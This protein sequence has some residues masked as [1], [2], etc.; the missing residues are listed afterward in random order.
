MRAAEFWNEGITKASWEKL[1]ELA[2][3]HDFV[4]IGGWAAWLWTKQHKSRDIDIVVDFKELG[5]LR[6]KYDV[7]KNERLKKY[8]IRLGDFDVDIYTPF[9]SKLELPAEE[10]LLEKVKIESIRTISC[11]SP[12]ILKQGAE[13]DRRGTV[14]G[15]K[16]MIDIMALLLWAPINLQDYFGKLENH[17]K[18]KLREELIREIGLFN[19][20]ESEK[21]LGIKLNEF[22]RRKKE[23]VKKV[24]AL[25]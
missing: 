8:E 19:P 20:A 1:Q 4:V 25:K 21:Y 24:K 6:E 15:R 22:A 17:G 2:Q 18:E 13:I 3:Q 9:Y 23:L 16:D 7:S 5:R 12:L 11:E 10:L 14:K